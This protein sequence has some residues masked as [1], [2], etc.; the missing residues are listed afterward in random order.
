VAK[1]EPGYS[2][3]ATKR[4]LIDKFGKAYPDQKRQYHPREP[5]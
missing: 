3:S 2:E 5:K 1:D 4:R